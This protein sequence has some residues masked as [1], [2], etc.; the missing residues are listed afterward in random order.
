MPD[1]LPVRRIEH[2]LLPAPKAPS[3]ERAF[4]PAALEI[5]ETP[6]SPTIRITQLAIAAVCAAALVWSW[7]GRVDIIA[8]APGKIVS[9]A[10]TKLV[11]PEQ[12]GVVR[13]ILVADGEHVRK[14]QALIALDSTTALADRARARKAETQAHLD[15]ARL[16]ALAGLTE[17]NP[18]AGVAVRNPAE[19]AAA[20]SRLLAERA[21][22]AA[23][24]AAAAAD[25][26]GKTANL[27]GVTSTIRKIE[28]ELPLLQGQADIRARSMQHGFGSR[29]QY[30]ETEQ[31]FKALDSDLAV[32]R[33]HLAEATAAV[34]SAQKA[35]ARIVADFTSSVYGQLAD[36]ERH[37]AAATD[38]LAKAD[39]ALQLTKLVAPVSGTVQDLAVHTSGAVVTPAQQLLSIVPDTG[40]L[41]VD[42]VV[43]NRDRGFVRPGQ[44]AVIK[45][46]TF[47]FTRYGLLHGT[48]QRVATDAVLI[49]P[50]GAGSGVGSVS[51]SA[52]PAALTAPTRLVY[53]ARV[54]L[55]RTE[56]DIDG[57]NVALLPGMAVTVE[58][59]T[60]R[61][62]VLD[63]LLAP[64]SQALHDS[65]HER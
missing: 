55:D 40:G 16:K 49:E 52:S 14:G 28:A 32:E 8:T 56:M 17:G 11:Q 39:R 35:R 30:L 25:L 63:Y 62:R 43:E 27:A 58:V 19:L 36:A 21:A 61:R 15:I 42:A 34:Q 64:L 37:L 24:L 45:I 23:R 51:A 54:S 1:L 18:F 31:Q 33:D 44:A 46:T 59:K 41:A 2:P 48:V 38:T 26:A 3:V 22:E 20:E 57:R 5:V 29:L 6:A 53:T 47:P 60:G 10:R 50:P 13:S 4:L 7:I 12:L 9:L 65:L